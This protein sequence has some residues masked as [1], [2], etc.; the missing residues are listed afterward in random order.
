MIVRVFCVYM[1]ERTHC[2]VDLCPPPQRVIGGESGAGDTD[3]GRGN[4]H[5]TGAAVVQVHL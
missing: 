1:Y 4:A 3:G 2:V 5:W